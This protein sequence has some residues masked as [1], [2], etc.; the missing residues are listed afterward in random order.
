MHTTANAHA[1]TPN[2][3]GATM[4]GVVAPVYTQ[5]YRK[6]LRQKYFSAKKLT[7]L[8]TVVKKWDEILGAR[9]VL[10]PWCLDCV[11]SVGTGRSN[12]V[13]FLLRALDCVPI[14][15][16]TISWKQG[17]SFSHIMDLLLVASLLDKINFAIP[18]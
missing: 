14:L 4:L 5:P 2:I 3:V 18:T 13:A 6:M 8:K 10:L 12:F 7:L 17:I 1:T 9:F 11:T 16:L 15:T